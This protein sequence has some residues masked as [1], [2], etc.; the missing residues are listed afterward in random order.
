VTSFGVDDVEPASDA[1]PTRALRSLWPEAMAIG[2]D[3]ELPVLEPDGVHPLLS[4]V[5][6]AFAGHRPLVLSPD[7]VWLTI[8]QGVAQH[9][10]LHAEELRPR[11][12]GRAGRKRL[13]VE[14][15]R[16]MPDD[17]ES[18][19]GLVSTFATAAE[20]TDAE[21]F[22]CDFSTST[23]VER[24][25]GRIIMLDACSSYFSL[26]LTC[27]CG[28]PAITL[29]GTA[30]D[31][32]R[33]RARVDSIAGFGLDR[34]CRS[35]APIADHFV[36]AAEGRPDI[37]FWQRIYS[38]VDAYGGEQVTGWV[39]RF[40]PYLLGFSVLDRP[41]HLLDL[42]IGEPRELTVAGQK[43]HGP[44]I[45]TDD[46]PAGLSRVVVSV[47]DRVR[48]DNRVVAL[49]AG[50]V[51][52]TQ[53]A[54]GALRPVAGWHLTAAPVEIDDVLDRIVRDHETEP[55]RPDGD[56]LLAPADVLALY[57][58]IRSATLF[59]GSWRVL[60]VRE[61]RSIQW[62]SGSSPIDTIIELAD[63][64]RVGSVLDEETLVV[65]WTICRTVD[66][67]L[68][69]DP[70][71]V[72]LLGS[73]LALLLDAALEAGGDIAHLETGRLADLEP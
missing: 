44:G 68:A 61:H 22:A 39:T 19:G 51:G 24:T 48:G 33:I 3:P 8:A 53:D 63:G 67:R 71:G 17:A 5:G 36:R 12:V 66:S 32:R 14:I 70:A 25:A 34:W 65:H 52:V 43:Y 35:L 20:I 16:A 69:E 45:R 11:L 15:D 10:R 55:A 23:D 49:H 54:D 30:G 73:S 64:R 41:N 29:T 58:R 21:L 60:P 40:Y 72:P 13:T 31:W 38:P 6:R 59:G 46:V 28:I 27:V 1:L 7:A 47:N 50:L 42:P 2:G 9:V 18:W 4:A 62:G 26:W 37:A 56:A 57:R